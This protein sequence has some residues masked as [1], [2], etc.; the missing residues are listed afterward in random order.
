MKLNLSYLCRTVSIEVIESNI[1]ILNQ[2]FKD[3]KKIG[4]YTHIGY[5]I[6]DDA[7]KTTKLF[8]TNIG[9]KEQC[10]EVSK[11][12]SKIMKVHSPRENELVL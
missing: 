6:I 9:D 8:I 4:H 11:L 2:S 12:V 3:S 5:E 7:S 10:A 1:K